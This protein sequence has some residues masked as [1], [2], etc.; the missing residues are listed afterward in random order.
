[1]TDLAVAFPIAQNAALR[2][3]T[4]LR[5][6]MGLATARI[7]SVVPENAPFP[8]VVRGQ[9]QIVET[10]HDCG[11]QGQIFSTVNIWSKPEPSSDAE[12]RAIGAAVKSALGANLALDGHVIDEWDV[13]TEAYST[14]PD[15]SSRGRLVLHYQTTEVVA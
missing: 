11:V 8:Y 9:D 13:Q 10:R 7:Y 5:A 12:V 14:D 4:D 3:S 6:A 2:A 15:G 1:M